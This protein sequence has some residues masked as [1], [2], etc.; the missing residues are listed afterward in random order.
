[1]P[2]LA[3]SPSPPSTQ[4]SFCIRRFDANRRGNVSHQM[5]PPLTHVKSVSPIGGFRSRDGGGTKMGPG[6]FFYSTDHCDLFSSVRKFPCQRLWINE[7]GDRISAE[8]E[9][10]DWSSNLILEEKKERG[11]PWSLYLG[12]KVCPKNSSPSVQVI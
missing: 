8:D 5:I 7:Y 6:A 4:W 9:M 12:W 10:Q 1:M 3:N 11:T 2:N